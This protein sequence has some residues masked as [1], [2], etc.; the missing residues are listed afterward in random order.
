MSVC[1]FVL[2][3]LLLNVF[4]LICTDSFSYKI[5]YSDACAYTTWRIS[6]DLTFTDAAGDVLFDLVEFV[7]R[8]G[9][10]DIVAVCAGRN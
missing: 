1:A 10:I 6:R 7:V 5:L 4:V 9:V 8:R 2:V 3:C